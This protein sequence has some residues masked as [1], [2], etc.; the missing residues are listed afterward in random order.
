MRFMMIIKGNK[1]SESGALPDEKLIADM[2]KYNEEMAKAGV[3]LDLTGLHPT[4]KG[5]LVKL[6]KDKVRV[7]DGPFSEAKE[8]IAGYW[9]IQVKSKEEA[10]EWAKRIPAPSDVAEGEEG[11]IEIR[12]VFELDEFG[13]SEAVDRARDLENH[14]GKKN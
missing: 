8:V 2:G 3:L 1:Q 7:I 6:S 5:A 14:L 13:P 11:E 12:Q 10:I 4:S 9:M